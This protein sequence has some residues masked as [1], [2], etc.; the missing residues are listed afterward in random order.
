MAGWCSGSTPARTTGERRIVTAGLPPRAQSAWAP[1]SHKCLLFDGPR[2]ERRSQTRQGRGR[3]LRILGR[4]R[5]GAHRGP[6]KHRE[7]QAQR[8]TST[9]NRPLCRRQPG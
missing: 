5:S 2:Q 4:G 8:T 7:L 3:C 9:E 1:H 6:S